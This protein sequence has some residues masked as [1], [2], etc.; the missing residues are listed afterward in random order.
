VLWDAINHYHSPETVQLD[1]GHLSDKPRLQSKLAAWPNGSGPGGSQGLFLVLS[2]SMTT[3]VIIIGGGISGLSAAYALIQAGRSVMV[4]EAKERFG[5]RVYT[6]GTPDAPIELGAEFLHGHD[7]RLRSAIRKANLTVRRVLN[8]NRR[9]DPKTGKLW[10][11]DVWGV[12]GEIIER[13][14]ARGR[15][16]PFSD[17]LDAQKLPD[18]DRRLALAFVEGFHAAHAETIGAHALLR[19]EYAADQIKGTSQGRLQQ[20]YGSLVKHLVSE[21][22]SRAGDL[23]AGVAVQQIRW[24]RDFV[25]VITRQGRKL[26]TFTGNQAIITLPLGVLKAFSSIRRCGRRRKPS[27]GCTLGTS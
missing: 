17:F 3:P 5:G 24:K 9:F 15:D 4:L 14:N 26:V 1:I 22:R 8:R 16:R 23:R 11:V 10:P 6:V 19:S 20:G 21:I 25:Q 18:P 7:P 27:R 13:V 2:C 12:M